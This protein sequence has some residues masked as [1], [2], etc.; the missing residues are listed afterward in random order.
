[1]CKHCKEWIGTET[2]F[3]FFPLAEGGC[4]C[5]KAPSGEV[6][7]SLGIAAGGLAMKVRK[8]GFG[9]FGGIGGLVVTCA[10]TRECRTTD[11]VTKCTPWECI[12]P[13]GCLDLPK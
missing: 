7:M 11:G 10:C 8:P 13:P 3:R 5:G 1:M 9:S 4:G 2:E 6:G 12:G